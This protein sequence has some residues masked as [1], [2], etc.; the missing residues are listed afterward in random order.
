MRSNVLVTRPRA[1]SATEWC[2]SSA[3]LL[4]HGTSRCTPSPRA[5]AAPRP[6]AMTCTPTC[7]CLEHQRVADL[8]R[9]G[10]GRLDVVNRSTT[11]R[12]H[13]HANLLGQQLRTDLVAQTSHGARTRAN[14]RDPDP[15][16][17]LGEVRILRDETPTHPRG[18]RTRLRQRPF[19][20]G[21]I[22]VG[23]IHG[24]AE[25]VCRV[26][27]SHEHGRPLTVGVEGDR[28]DL[29]SAQRVELPHG[30]DQ[31]HRGLSAV[32]DR[33]TAD[34][35]RRLPE[36][37]GPPTLEVR[38]CS[39]RSALLWTRPTLG[40]D[41]T[42]SSRRTTISPAVTRVFH[43]AKHSQTYAR[44]DLQPRSRTEEIRLE[45]PSWLPDAGRKVTWH[46]ETT[47]GRAA[48]YDDAVST[49]R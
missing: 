45:D 14:E 23:A 25:G 31:S 19:E 9:G 30:V 29:G 38:L 26:R 47:D 36:F 37:G 39:R 5:H 48:V 40:A 27:L 41:A 2:S 12:G 28:L 10:Q 8:A 43:G 34:H 16:A 24:G 42:R 32:D 49:P 35:V 6:S 22:E 15:V 21:Q 3:L 20:H 33:D 46:T 17:H 13:R 11:P 44:L 7:R 1:P 4:V 18:I